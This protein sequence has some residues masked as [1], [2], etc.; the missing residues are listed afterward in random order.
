MKTGR[1]KQPLN[2]PGRLGAKTRKRGNIV[3][4]CVCV[5]DVKPFSA[6]W[7]KRGVTQT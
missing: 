2:F 6:H 5:R 3:C 4:A 7:Q 1:I